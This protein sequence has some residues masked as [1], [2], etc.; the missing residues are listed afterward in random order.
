[1]A[2]SES[3]PMPCASEHPRLAI[4]T[5]LHLGQSSHPPP[6]QQLAETLSNFAKLAASVNAD[7]A[8]VAVD[9]ED[10]LEGY[11]LVAEVEGICHRINEQIHDRN[12]DPKQQP[13]Q[14]NLQQQPSRIHVLPVQPWG[15]FIPALNAIVAYSARQQAQCLLFASAEVSIQGCVMER[16]WSEMNLEDTLVVGAALQGHHHQTPPS[17]TNEIEVE[18]TGRTCPWNTFALWNLPK[19]SLTGFLQVSEGL[20]ATTGEA[21]AGIEEVCT[22]ATLQRIFPQHTVKAKLVKICPPA[23]VEWGQDF[24]DDEARREWHERKMRSKE[25]RAK[26][27]LDLLGLRGVVIHC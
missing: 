22:I 1:M 21:S 26:N 12:R 24:N 6:T 8:V 13:C 15:K 17:Q 10:K 19:L 2:Q 7:I 11:S 25:V 14:D 9:A 18:L 3:H 27:Q 20:H 5:R 23:V 4:A 16:M